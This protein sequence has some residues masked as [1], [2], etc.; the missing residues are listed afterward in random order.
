MNIRLLKATLGLALLGCVALAR[1]PESELVSIRLSP[2]SIHS[3]AGGKVAVVMRATITDGWHINSNKP[4]DEFLVP[5]VVTAKSQGITLT[6][7]RYPGAQEI[8]LSFAEKPVS[9]YE[10]S[11]DFSLVLSVAA[12]APPGKREVPVQ[13][14]YQACNDRSCMPPTSVNATLVIEVSIA[15]ADKGPEAGVT[16]LEEKSGR[17]TAATPLTA[18]GSAKTDGATKAGEPSVVGGTG[19]SSVSVVLALAFAFLGGLILNLMPCVLPVL[20]LKIMG[21]VQQAGESPRERFR[22]GLMF[23]LGVV[24]S[25]WILSGVLLLLRAGGEQLGWGFQLQSPSFVVVLAVFLFMFGLNMFGVF[26]I[27]TS[28]T[29]VGQGVGRKSAYAGS[30][31]SGVLATT[32][33]TPC[34]APFMGSALGFALGQPAYVAMLIFTFLGLGMAAPY[35]LLTTSPKLLKMIPKPGAWMET[36]KH[37]MAFLLMATVLWLLWVL[38]LQT[39]AD[40]VLILLASLLL[41]AVAG[42]VLGRWGNIAKE[43][44]TRR[45]AQAIAL[46]CIVGAL[47][48]SL[49]SIHAQKPIIGNAQTQ[50]TIK[51]ME[52]SPELVQRLRM[53]GKPVF[54]DFTAAWCLSCQVNDRVAFGSDEVQ[55]AFREKGIAA[56]KADWTNRDPVIAAGLAAFGRNSVPLY[57]FYPPGK[58]AVLL[59]EILTPG[60]VLDA[61]ENVGTGR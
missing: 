39:G 32:V 3:V 52:Y 21:M 12:G 30:F 50:G 37:V 44:T 26:E 51:W 16:S 22:H 60:I 48:F 54:I 20:S 45:V 31:T 6:S 49:T 40:G 41:V 59:P 29:A 4:N 36:M 28:L 27:G 24:V 8:Q 35:L 38:G 23:A 11:V 47:T 10:G 17:D 13:L 43:T 5:T 19:E 2:A 57:V 34:T 46:V 18:R 55:N 56:L 58:E 42:W 14:D 25:F 15:P 1:G 53:E 33:A 9:V 7:V 61:L